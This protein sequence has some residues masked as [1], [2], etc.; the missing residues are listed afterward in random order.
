M[1][2]VSSSAKIDAS[3]V[4]EL[5]E[6]EAEALWALSQYSPTGI[7]DV[8]Q[9]QDSYQFGEVVKGLFESFRF[10]IGRSLSAIKKARRVAAQLEPTD[11][12][13]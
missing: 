8:M 1:A 3:V 7:V 11:A 6:K 2:K 9:K 5:T 10:E 4:F 13:A 12:P